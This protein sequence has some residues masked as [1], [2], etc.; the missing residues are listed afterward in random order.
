MNRQIPIAVA[1]MLILLPTS[2]LS[3]ADWTGF[4]GPTG[5][6]TSEEKGLPVKWSSTE[7][8]VWKVDLPGPGASSPIVVG[9]KVFVTAYSGYGL[10][11][12]EGDQKDLRRHLLCLNRKTGD[13]L[14][15][16]TFEPKL[17]EHIYAGEGAYQGY[18]GNTPVTDGE[19]LYVFF[20]KSGV[21][22]FDL[23]GNEKWH[24][25]VGEGT[26]G[27]G[28][29]TSPVL[30]G[31]LLIV[32]A[33]VESSSLVALDKKTG[34]EVWKTK[35]IG[36]SWNTPQIAKTKQGRELVV[37]IQD[38]IVGLKP[39]T[40]VEL[41]RAEGVHRYVCPSVV[42]HDDVVYA[43]GGGHT[44]LAVRAGGRGDVSKTHVFWRVEKGSNVGSPIFDGGNLYWAEDSAGTMEC[45]N[46]A[47]GEKVYQGRFQPGSGLIW[48][49][50]ILADG[51]IY[52]VS[53]NNGTFV[54]AAGPKFEQLSHNKFEDDDSRT[55]ASPAVADGKI[56]LRTDKRLYCIGGK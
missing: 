26:N 51:K 9:D 39:D 32:N 49:S 24:V 13:K 43:I 17:P 40:G 16:K 18:A 27:W 46:A 41:W 42:T 53:Q 20:G 45:Q 14:W 30:F 15:D 1:S 34:E 8:I 21:H 48:S 47:T 7:N 4:R 6:G 37:S 19:R 35:G 10:K 2:L 5:Q 44:S 25:S 55:N 28:S 52:V 11:A 31:N 29:G 54:L 56:Y 12:N 36:S 50:P 38:W 3:A 23:E 22:C 33:S